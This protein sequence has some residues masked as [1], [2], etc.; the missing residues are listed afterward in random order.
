MKRVIFIAAVLCTA[1]A[2]GVSAQ[3]LKGKMA[4]SAFGGYTMGLGD[5]F[6]DSDY[7]I[8]PGFELPPIT[9]S[10]SF[11]AGIDAGVMFHFGVAE[12]IMIGLEID[13][14]QYKSKATVDDYEVMGIPVPGMSTEETQTK[15]N[16]L[17]NLMYAISYSET[18]SGTFLTVGAGIYGGLGGTL[19]LKEA[20]TAESI[21]SSGSSFGINGGI[22]FRKMVGTSVGLFIMPRLHYVFSDP[23]SKLLMISGG[24]SIPFGG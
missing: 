15:V 24:I 3:G 13:M 11:D 22:M 5:P 16:L 9:G 10:I 12:K 4:L 14:Q 19:S 21:E 17:G 6:S 8:Y 7:S 1:F 20:T 23:N 18:G 2:L